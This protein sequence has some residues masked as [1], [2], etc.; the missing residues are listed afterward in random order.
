MIRQK[1]LKLTMIEKMSL[2][3]T[4]MHKESYLIFTQSIGKVW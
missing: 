1:Y 4:K 2:Y 3:S